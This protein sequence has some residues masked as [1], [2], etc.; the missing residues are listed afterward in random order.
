[1]RLLSRLEDE[2]KSG[3][4]WYEIFANRLIR[5]LYPTP[6]ASLSLLRKARNLVY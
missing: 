6:K 2:Q 4:S 1:M 5:E 3:A